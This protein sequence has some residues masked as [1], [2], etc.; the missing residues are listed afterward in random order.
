[1][2]FSDRANIPPLKAVGCLAYTVLATLAVL[3][4]F[5]GSVM[6]DC[7]EGPYDACKDGWTNFLMFP[8]SL[9]IAIVIG[10]F[11]ARWAMRNESDD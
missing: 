2:S 8:G 1:V 11:L 9:I 7:A 4:F 5:I 3:F 6:G 10:I